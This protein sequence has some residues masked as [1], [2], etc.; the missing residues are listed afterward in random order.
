MDKLAQRE[1]EIAYVCDVCA[2]GDTTSWNE[3]GFSIY[4]LYKKSI[5]RYKK[6]LSYHGIPSHLVDVKKKE[7]N[8]WDSE[9]DRWRLDIEFDEVDVVKHKEEIDFSGSWD[10]YV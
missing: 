4:S 2:E 8:S 9:S 7:G 3:T 10:Y 6:S 1:A 5:L